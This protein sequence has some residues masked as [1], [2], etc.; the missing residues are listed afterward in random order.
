M[1]SGDANLLLYAMNRGCADHPAAKAWL[2]AALAKP[3]EL[4]FSDQV[5]FEL[6]RLLRHPRVM[7]Q[8]LPALDALAQI[9]WFREETG[10]LHCGYE[11][12]RWAGV[13]Q[14]LAA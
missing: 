1:N 14:A 6:Y 3:R 5:L 4:I 7:T 11:E 10:F 8:A 2:E 13:L 12:S 9:A